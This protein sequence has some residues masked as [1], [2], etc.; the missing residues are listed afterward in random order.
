[1]RLLEG[2]NKSNAEIKAI[3][4]EADAQMAEILD[5]RRQALAEHVTDYRHLGA[6]LGSASTAVRVT[7]AVL[8]AFEHTRASF[9]TLHQQRA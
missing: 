7:E 6:E 8:A 2:S 1:M 4:K 3:R 9:D 5:V